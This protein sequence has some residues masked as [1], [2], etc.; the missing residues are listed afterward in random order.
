[1][2]CALCEDS[3]Q[4]APGQADLS[5]RIAHMLLC[6]PA[7]TDLSPFLHIAIYMTSHSYGF[8]MTSLL[9]IR[10]VCLHDTLGKQS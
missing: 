10:L 6:L 1:M 9:G 8:H 3:D 5:L 2:A 4:P 7:H